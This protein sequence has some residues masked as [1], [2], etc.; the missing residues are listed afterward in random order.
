MLFVPVYTHERRPYSATLYLTSFTLHRLLALR[1][2]AKGKAKGWWFSSGSMACGEILVWRQVLGRERKRAFEAIGGSTGGH[3]TRDHSNEQKSRGF[4]KF[5]DH[6]T[7]L[8]G[9]HTRPQTLFSYIV[10]K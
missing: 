1:T 9:A 4:G 2:R 6:S 7:V 8:S 10:S 3:S 5:L